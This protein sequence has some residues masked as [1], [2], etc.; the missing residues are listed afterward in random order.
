MENIEKKLTLDEVITIATQV[1]I[2]V[3]HQEMQKIRLEKNKERFD[4]RLRN[5]KLLLQN[6]RNFKVYYDES[7]Y[8]Q[9]C[10]ALDILDEL[11]AYEGDECMVI[12]SIN[13]S[14]ERTQIILS[15][16]LK[17]MQMFRWIMESSKK[18]EDVRKY[19]TIDMLYIDDEVKTADEIAKILNVETRTVHR[20]KKEGISIL[21]S[22][23]F[24]VDGVKLSN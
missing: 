18:D 4:K 6:F 15:H 1:G 24:G 13:H 9:N 21:S 16:I 14:R 22:L 19:K 11:E 8:K 12:E 20:Y 5:T 3:A 2:K 10:S 23:M 17:M 7:V